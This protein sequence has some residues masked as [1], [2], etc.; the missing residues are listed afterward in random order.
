MKPNTQKQFKT[1]LTGEFF[2]GYGGE[3]WVKI[4]D[5]IGIVPQFHYNAVVVISNSDSR[6]GG[7]GFWKDEDLVT[8]TELKLQDW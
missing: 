8:V 1:L 7:M 3:I 6:P 5:V 2:E 4:K